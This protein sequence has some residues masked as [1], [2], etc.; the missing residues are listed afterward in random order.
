MYLTGCQILTRV[1]IIFTVILDENI[2]DNCIILAYHMKRNNRIHTADATN[3]NEVPMLFYY[4]VDPANLTFSESQLFYL[5]LDSN[6]KIL[7]TFFS[8]P[9]SEQIS[10]Y[11]Q[12][13]QRS[14]KVC[15]DPKVSGQFLSLWTTEN[16]TD[17]TDSETTVKLNLF[18]KWYNF[19]TDGRQKSPSVIYTPYLPF[20]KTRPQTGFCWLNSLTPSTAY[21]FPN[22]SACPSRASTF[23]NT[24][25]SSRKFN[26]PAKRVQAARDGEDR[27]YAGCRKGG[28]IVD[29]W[30]LFFIHSLYT[31]NSH[32]ARLFLPSDFSRMIWKGFNKFLIHRFEI[33]VRILPLPLV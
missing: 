4:S 13:L 21:S 26:P 1:E 10:K 3:E 12:L 11:T 25:I 33:D 28:G 18:K 5:I 15:D 16:P 23:R 24:R 6:Q 17:S 9:N 31:D 7:R 8:E 27:S 32:C 20:P 14:K 30:I 29:Y 2:N 22:I 19:E